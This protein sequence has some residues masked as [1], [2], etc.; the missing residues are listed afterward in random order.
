M[1]SE[2]LYTLVPLPEAFGLKNAKIAILHRSY[3]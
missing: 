1:I 3:R 2:K